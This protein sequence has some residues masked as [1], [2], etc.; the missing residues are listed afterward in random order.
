M[1]GEAF[2]KTYVALD[3][4]LREKEE[5]ERSGCT[6]IAAII[7]PTHIVV[8]NAGDSR[9]VLGTNNGLDEKGLAQITSDLRAHPVRVIG[10]SEMSGADSGVVTSSMEIDREVIAALMKLFAK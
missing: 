6:A 2:R 7:T 5:V 8:A 10:H 3:E 1:L 4:E 9:C